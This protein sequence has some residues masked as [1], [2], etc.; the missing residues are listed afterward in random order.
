MRSDAT[1]AV[2]YLVR[3]ADSGF[4]AALERF[5]TSYRQYSAGIDHQLYVAFKAFNTPSE[6]EHAHSLLS[7]IPY[8]P[9]DVDD[10]GFDIGTYATIARRTREPLI[11][12]LNTHTEIL[13]EH[14]LAKLAGVI[15]LNGAGLA[16]ATG[17]LESMQSDLQPAGSFPGFPNIHLRTNAFIIA[18]ELFCAVTDG[19]A[20]R[21]KFD[22]HSFE[23]GP[24]SMTRKILERGL[25][26]FVVGRNGRG[27]SPRWWPSS[28]TFRQG[29]QA[30]LLAADNQTRVYEAAPWE[31]K[32]GF[33]QRT[34]GP[35]LNSTA[36]IHLTAR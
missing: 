1:I 9:L 27:Y 34:W 32:R 20:F 31:E 17:S 10:E 28:E 8:T 33:A 3:A 26:V 30:N 19:V 4:E 15:G 18:R 11:C 2:C 29:A 14:W 6:R 16:G 7:S 12:F 13:C 25:Q 36:R 35:Y 23:S 21:T 5:A 22:A 24:Q